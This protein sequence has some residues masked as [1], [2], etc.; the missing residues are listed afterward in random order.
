MFSPVLGAGVQPLWP[1]LYETFGEDPL[2][3][4]TMG[5]AF[6]ASAQST[7]LNSSDSVAA[8]AKHLM[9]YSAPRSGKDRTD[10]W[11]P[12]P[13]LRQYFVPA[14]QAAFDAGAKTIMINSASINGMPVHASKPILT[15]LV[16]EQMGFGDGLAVTDWQVRAGM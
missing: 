16:R 5:A 9:G 1:R 13:Y 11:L 12:E 6:I 8:T 7:G 10:A 15:S 2:V 14:F 4:S 3:G